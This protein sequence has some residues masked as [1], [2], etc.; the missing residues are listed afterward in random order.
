M[1]L[2]L[3]SVMLAAPFYYYERGKF[4]ISPAVDCR[5]EAMVKRAVEIFGPSGSK[6]ADQAADLIKACLTIDP[7]QRPTARVVADHLNGISRSLE[8]IE[9]FDA[10]D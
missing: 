7:Y 8:V 10:R 2:G 6:S 4:S 5:L 1:F 3:N 9:G